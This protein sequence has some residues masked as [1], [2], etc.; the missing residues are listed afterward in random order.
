MS[1]DNSAEVLGASEIFYGM[2]AS[3]P[4]IVAVAPFGVLFGTLAVENGFSTFEA[5][6][7]SATIYAGASQMV[8]LE[9]FGSN[10]APWLIVVSIFAVNFRHV[11]YS[12][13]IGRNTTQWTPLQRV[14]GFFF[15]G[16]PQFAETERR[17]EHGRRV[18]FSWYMG[19]G[20]PIYVCWV[21]EAWIGALFG[22]LVS[23]P[24]A[25]GIDFLL[26]IY[27]LGLVMGFRKRAMWLPVVGVSAVA[28]IAAYHTVG[29]PWH[30][31]VGAFAGILLGALLPLRLSAEVEKP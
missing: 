26:P 17:G 19:L 1:A 6:L 7:M 27:F 23:D 9:L 21:A 16:D 2:R 25:L 8:G 22:R 11:L 24:H 13:A 5:I 28:T 14:V 4:V 3:L 12:A 10:V 30:V 29:S 20:L 15:L 31:S 18:S